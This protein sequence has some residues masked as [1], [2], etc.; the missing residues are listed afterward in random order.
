LD[1]EHEHG[2]D[3]EGE[4]DGDQVHGLIVGPRS[5]GAI[6]KRDQRIQIL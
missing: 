6:E 3:A 2:E 4:D 5:E 1:E